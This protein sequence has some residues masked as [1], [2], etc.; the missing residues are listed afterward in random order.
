MHKRK[1]GLVSYVYGLKR[2]FLKIRNQCKILPEMDDQTVN[3]INT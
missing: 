2:Q 1:P 3:V